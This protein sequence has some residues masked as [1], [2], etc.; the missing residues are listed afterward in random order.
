MWTFLGVVGAALVVWALVSAPPTGPQP[1]QPAPLPTAFAEQRTML[2]QV[3]NDADLGADNMVAGVGGGLPPAQLLVASQLI[4]DV[5]GAGQQTLAQSARLLDRSASQ[6]ALSDLL[7]L[8]IDGTLSLARLALAGMVDFVGGVTVTVDQPITVTDDDT[9]VETVVVPAGTHLLDGTQAATYALAW[10]PDEPEAARMARYSQVMTAA[11]EGLPDDALRIQEMLT[12]LGG[13]AR[14]TASTSD[15][16]EFL[17]AMRTS[18]RNGGQQVRVLPTTEIEAGQSLAVVRVDLV[19]ADAV[20]SSL[21]PQAML[22]GSDANARV[23]VQ[24]GVGTPALGASARDR[25]VD[26]GMVYV[27]GGN[28]AQ[29]GQKETLVIIA[30]DTQASVDV[31]EEVAE[32]LEVPVTSVQVAED[33]QNVADVVVILG[34]DYEP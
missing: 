17:L 23:L 11:I 12:S 2:L 22:S 5:P 15:V 14:T 30:D 32:A 1:P 7:S 13:S 20:L 28:A 4:V 29:F 25:L 27:N 26:A 9:E 3:R 8:R 34:K 10:L 19:A 6:D 33:G 31:G 21:L 18:I 16:A 24:N